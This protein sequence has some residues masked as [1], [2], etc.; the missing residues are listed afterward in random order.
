[1]GEQSTLRT[2]LSVSEPNRA[3]W[4]AEAD[5]IVVGFGGAGVVAALQAC[6]CGARVIAVDRFSGGGATAYSGGVIYA[7]GTEYQRQSGFDD[8]PEEMF[9]Y[10]S[11][12]GSAVSAET[13]RRFCEGS[14]GDLEW[15][16]AHGVPHGANAF[17]EKTNFPPDGYWIY[18]SGNEKLPAFAAKAKPAPR[19]HRARTT[20]F[21]GHL[22]YSRLRESALSNGVELIEHAPVERL[23]VDG[24]GAVIGVEVNAL[25]S[26]AWKRHSALYS[27]VNPWRPFS[28]ARGERAIAE[29]ARLER[30]AGGRRLL[31]AHRGVVLATGGFIY[32]L[33]TLRRYRPELADNYLNLL[34][35]GS[36]GDDGSGLELGVSV[37]GRTAMMDRICIA[38]TIA[39]PNAFPAGVIVNARGERFINE[40]A[41]AFVVGNAVAGQPQDGKAW[42]ILDA[43]DFHTGVKQS[44]LPGK[45]LFLTWGAPALINILLGGTRRARSLAALARKCRVDPNGLE[46]TVRDYNAAIVARAPD[47]LGKY[48]DLV[49]PIERGPFYAVNLSLGNRFSPAQTFTLGGLEVDEET[50]G[51]R[52]PDRTVILGLYAAGRVAIGL[53]SNGYMSGLSI[54]DT[55]FSGRRAGRAAALAARGPGNDNRASTS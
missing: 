49:H 33:E 31:R 51:V 39:P 4:G 43:H 48:P 10:L 36:M 21:G 32:N 46:R 15:L 24:N 52:G 25:P 26:S 9:K 5:V 14:A 1:M 45:G 53:C 47:P 23:I 11:A 50:G 3:A 2:P 7:G 34:R 16:E 18:Y 40:D 28:G 13:L 44:L 17:L 8:T 29:C 22:H 35:L 20:G 37:G 12:E 19:G 6:E 54:A 38:R 55:V 41:Y 30:S 27:A 42:L